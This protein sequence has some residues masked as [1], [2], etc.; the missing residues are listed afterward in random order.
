EDCGCCR[1]Y[2]Y[3]P[4][5]SLCLDKKERFKNFLRSLIRNQHGYSEVIS[6]YFFRSLYQ[7]VRSWDYY[8]QRVKL[9][10]DEFFRCEPSWKAE[11]LNWVLSNQTNRI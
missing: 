4:Y 7:V 10:L 3:T 6:N 1:R 11:I 8:H 2:Y 5:R 9:R